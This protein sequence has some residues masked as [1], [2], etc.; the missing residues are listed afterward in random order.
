MYENKFVLLQLKARRLY[1]PTPT[2]RL[3][4]ATR[5]LQPPTVPRPS[6]QRTTRQHRRATIATRDQRMVRRRR[7][8]PSQQAL[9]LL[10]D[11]TPRTKT[12]Y[13]LRL[14][15]FNY[16]QVHEERLRPST[17]STCPTSRKAKGPRE[18]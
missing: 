16:F 17:A 12:R 2:P 3:Q 10:L 1:A 11:D 6:L 15:A 7:R 5:C 13:R 14:S 18:S 8:L 4:P 9:I